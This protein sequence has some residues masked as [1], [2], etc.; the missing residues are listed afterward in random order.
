MH[1]FKLHKLSDHLHAISFIVILQWKHLHYSKC[2]RFVGKIISTVSKLKTVKQN[3][4][5][6]IRRPI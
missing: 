4:R 5:Q 1:F 2:F 3:D 6:N